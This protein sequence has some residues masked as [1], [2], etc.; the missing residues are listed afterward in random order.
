M[1]SDAPAARLL[2]LLDR[3][4]LDAAIEAGLA[5]VDPE[6]LA[7]LSSADRARLEQARQRLLQAW[8]ARARHR[9]RNARLARRAEALRERRAGAAAATGPLR[10][11]LPPAA[12]A[13]LARARQRARDRRP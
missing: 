5:D 3:D 12:A 11:D 8:A 2:R 1:N 9:A 13:A 6:A 10:A 7:P 4:D